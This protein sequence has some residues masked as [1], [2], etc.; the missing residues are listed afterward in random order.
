MF[1][2]NVDF[3]RRITKPFGL[4]IFCNIFNITLNLED[5]LVVDQRT[6]AHFVLL[7]SGVKI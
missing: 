6:T 4:S 2:D 3:S 1:V 5:I 7:K